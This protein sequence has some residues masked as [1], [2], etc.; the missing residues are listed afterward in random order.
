MDAWIW[1]VI[2]IVAI[3]AVA[4]G[5]FAWLQARSRRLRDTFGP[6][7]ERALSDAPSRR[8]ELD[9]RPLSSDAA[10]RYIHEWEGIQVRF[11]DDPVGATR[12]AD[13]LVG[14]VMS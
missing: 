2:A 8:E 5:V 6:E 14:Q 9:I 4:L 1:V 3:I 12:D 13:R 10:G 7:Y 11:V